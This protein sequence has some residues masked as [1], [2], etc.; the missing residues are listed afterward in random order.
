VR[1]LKYTLTATP[2]DADGKRG[3]P[4]AVAVTP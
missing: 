3:K 1:D 4:V 2:I